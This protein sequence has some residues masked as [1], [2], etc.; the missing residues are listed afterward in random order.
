[1]L[2]FHL[3]RTLHITKSE[4]LI[5][6]ETWEV[7]ATGACMPMGQSSAGN[8][9]WQALILHSLYPSLLPRRSMAECQILIVFLMELKLFF[10]SFYRNI[11][12]TSKS[13]STVGNDRWTPRSPWFFSLQACFLCSPASPERTS[14][15]PLPPNICM[16]S[17]WTL[18]PA[19]WPAPDRPSTPC[20]WHFPWRL[21]FKS[22]KVFSKYFSL[23]FFRWNNRSGRSLPK[24]MRRAW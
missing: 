2:L 5:L 10:L 17:P 3:T 15:Q 6:L 9:K 11:S 8:D 12:P 14:L 21:L 13:L 1:M 19:H 24:A 23:P 7:L 18:L 22:L 16:F 20:P 4:Y